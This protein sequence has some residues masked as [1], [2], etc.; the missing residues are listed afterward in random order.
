M[1]ESF[2][3]GAPAPAETAPVVNE[4]AAEAPNPISTEGEP[5]APEVKEPEPKEPAKPISTREALDK[6]DAKVEAD[7]KPDAKAKDTPDPKAKDAKEPAKD[8]PVR[9]ETGKFASKDGAEKPAEAQ[10]AETAPKPASP[11]SDAPKRFSEDAKAAWATAPEPVKAEV[12]RMERELTQGL[13]KYKTSHEAYEQVR[14]YDEMAKANGRSLKEA[15]DTYVH[16]DRLI[17]QDPVK[18]IEALCEAKG[19]TLR[20]LAEKVLGQAPDQQAGQRDQEM[21]SLKNTIKQ[22]EQRLDQRLG[23][24][25]GRF[26]EQDKSRVHETVQQFA[27]KHPRFDELADEIEFFIKSERTKDLAE[28]YR[29]AELMKPAPASAPPPAPTPAPDSRATAQTRGAKSIT[30]APTA[31]SDPVKRQPSSSPREALLKAFAARG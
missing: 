13:E 26:E 31:G 1:T 6:A 24:V 17:G 20:Q 19:F 9:D 28:A 12:A 23:S 3:S 4:P 14:Q 27:A 18:G 5:K 25:E 29:L 22:L 10:P 2:D 7:N 11:A 30:G 15:L 21:I 16:L 8:A